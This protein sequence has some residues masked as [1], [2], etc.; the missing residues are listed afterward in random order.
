MA[1]AHLILGNFNESAAASLRFL[2][3]APN[4]PSKSRSQKK[5]ALVAAQQRDLLNKT[6]RDLANALT[7][8]QRYPEAL[9]VNDFILTRTPGS[10]EAHHQKAQIYTYVQDYN[11]AIPEFQDALGID[12]SRADILAD[13]GLA[14]SYNNDRRAI[15]VLQDGLKLQPDNLRLTLTI[16]SRISISRKRRFAKSCR[17]S[18]TTCRRLWLWPIRS[19]SPTGPT[20]R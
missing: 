3:V 6:L 15:N 20:N 8:A 16:T 5:R 7:Y 1:T 19:P 2:E 10:V 11:R 9:G 13:Y 17:A 12:P 4:A 18:R 14:L